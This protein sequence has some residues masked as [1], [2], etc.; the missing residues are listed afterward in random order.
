MT[1]LPDSVERKLR[2]LVDPSMN[3]HDAYYHAITSQ[4]R[5][6]LS[7]AHMAMEDEEVGT[8][9]IERV[10]NRMVYGHPS[11]AQAYER[12]DAQKLMMDAMEYQPRPMFF[13]GGPVK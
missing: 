11:G 8:E 5:S 13:P 3:S 7:S 1:E 2:H 6:W 9:T 12:Q 10:L 4:F